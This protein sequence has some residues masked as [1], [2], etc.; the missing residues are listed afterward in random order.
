MIF[1][2]GMS[3]IAAENLAKLALGKSY[4]LIIDDSAQTIINKNPSVI[5]IQPLFGV[6]FDKNQIIFT[7]KT[8]GETQVSIKGKKK[9]Y[10]LN[11]LV[12]NEEDIENTDFLELDSAKGSKK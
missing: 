11:I 12:G 10:D 8:F 2:T 9:I 1:L 5:A 6:D 4:L 3:T 7:P